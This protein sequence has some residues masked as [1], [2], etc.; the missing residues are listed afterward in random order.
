MN[1]VILLGTVLAL[2]A[3]GK[4]SDALVERGGSASAIVTDPACAKA[5]KH[6]DLAWLEDD[7][8]SALAC[9]KATHVPLVVDLWAPWCHT[10]LSMKSTVF[11]DKA[12]A[13]QADKFVWVSLDTDRETNA[14]AVAKLP[15]AAWPTFYVLGEDESVLA[16]FAGA[17][18]LAQFS[19]FLDAGLASRGATDASAQALLA[20]ERALAVKDFATADAQL[21]LAVSKA[22]STWSRL[23]DALV[24]WIHTK[25]SRND[26]AG[27]FELAENH[28]AGEGLGNA[29]S[30]ADFIGIA[31][32]CATDLL[33]ADPTTKDRVDTFRT[34]AIAELKKQ[35]SDANAPLSVD[36]RSDAMVYARELM[37]DLGDK[38]YAKETAEQQV[39]LLEDAIKNASEPMSA[40]TYNYQ[41]ADAF[42]FLERPLE[43]VPYLQKSATDLPNEYDPAARLANVYYEA[44]R[45]EDAKLWADK[46]LSLVYGPRKARVLEIRAN[47]A[48]A[49]GKRDEE[50][51]YRAQS[52]EMWKSLPAGQQNPVAQKKAED[53]LAA[54]DQPAQGSGSATK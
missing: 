45:Y 17:A 5:K 48:K 12:L 39:A 14:P 37:V 10:C 13:P 44:K 34:R 4:K 2:G 49:Q 1:R 18:S 9:A 3:C 27:C 22:P 53:A 19:A 52:V 28:V 31:A 33:K 36:D 20:A 47:V 54:L 43:A 30:V 46:A 15:L 25:K 41:L 24:S 38:E 35:Y 42:I 8:P 11:M 6:G 40:M 32:E 29:A 23:P 7:Y 16:R 26:D 51:L 50:K 21:Q